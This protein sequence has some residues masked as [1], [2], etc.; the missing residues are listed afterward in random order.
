MNGEARPGDSLVVAEVL[1][2]IAESVHLLGVQVALQRLVGLALSELLVGLFLE[3]LAERVPLVAPAAGALDVIVGGDP[4][5]RLVDEVL[6]D[7]I[8]NGFDPA[9]RDQQRIRVRR[10]ERSNAK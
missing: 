8:G 2:E 9:R 10:R 4:R 1:R 3:L 7:Q 5:H 6:S